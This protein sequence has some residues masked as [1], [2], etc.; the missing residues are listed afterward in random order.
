MS[1]SADNTE[2]GD[3]QEDP[4]VELARIVAEDAPVPGHRQSQPA[5][6]QTAAK[7]VVTTDVSGS[8][9]V[10]D[11]S[12]A[13]P[14]D[15]QFFDLEAELLREI[16]VVS[17]VGLTEHAAIPSIAPHDDGWQ[18]ADT[19]PQLSSPV[20]DGGVAAETGAD[21]TTEMPVTLEPQSDVALSAEPNLSLF[22]QELAA[23]VADDFG[24][25]A[26]QVALTRP[27]AD[28]VGETG[29]VY[30]EQVPEPLS[31]N[32]DTGYIDH[33]SPDQLQA[34]QIDPGENAPAEVDFGEAFERELAQ[35]T[36]VMPLPTSANDDWRS[37][38]PRSDH[39]DAAMTAGAPPIA[40]DPVI[41]PAEE[42]LDE[43]HELLAEG[44]Q[45]QAGHHLGDED[46]M[47][48]Q[49]SAALDAE[50][51][52]GPETGEMPGAE[53]YGDPIPHGDMR[54]AV[55]LNDGSASDPYR[56]ASQDEGDA[57]YSMAPG[58][59]IEVINYGRRRT[60]FLAAGVLL[61]ALLAGVGAAGLGMFSPSGQSGSP[62][63]IIAASNDPVKIR[64]VDPGGSATANEDN[65]VYASVANEN[66]ADAAGNTSQTSLV[67]GAEQPVAADQIGVAGAGQT[68]AAESQ[69]KSDERI[70]PTTVTASVD[71]DAPSAVVA[72]RKVQTVVVRSDGT[73]VSA[74]ADAANNEAAVVALQTAVLQ[75]AA[76]GTGTGGQGASIVV[77]ELPASTTP[78]DGG[79]TATGQIPVPKAI[80]QDR[81]N[82]PAAT[83]VTESN[84]ATEQAS[85]ALAE[86]RSEI[87]AIASDPIQ[88]TALAPAT[89]PAPAAKATP[90]V[91]S[92]GE[93]VV[94]ISSQRSED[95]AK[96]SYQS[97]KRRFA[98]LLDGRP[99]AIRRAN[100]EGKG[101]FYRVRIPV[102]SR[103][104]AT[105]FC[106]NFK[107]QGGSCFVT[108]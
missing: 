108:R 47:M 57:N 99:M 1:N 68:S 76:G 5:A 104:Q 15:P 69:S 85:A 105:K 25:I 4:L 26:D 64:P 33:P 42:A 43:L 49:F 58:E 13:V 51:T 59:E 93:Y 2:I 92:P 9:A 17:D 12:A 46:A 41:Q 56:F 23:L 61:I 54:A 18:T 28:A 84:S 27:T 34:D 67:S 95:A 107:A 90:V 96:A 82:P 78:F 88:V 73:I 53:E 19:A 74:V 48:D 87:A 81:P 39:E 10:A 7:P 24:E 62:A 38:A 20:S 31:A 91:T 86:A 66:D 83:I 44:T 101:I 94:Q 16:G 52:A 72:P 21:E 102:G 60:V 106:G 29:E 55:A 40:I 100:I 98:S 77:A 32:L 63:K 71:P 14:N 97:L 80:P 79:V 3:H 6:A 11:G 50:M 36:P 89:T 8:L 30:V 35:T 70:T 37:G 75:G 22:E 103:S 45:E 65:S